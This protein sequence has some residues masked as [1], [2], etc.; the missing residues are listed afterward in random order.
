MPDKIQRIKGTN[1]I[2]PGET[3][4][5]QAL[6]RV[7]Q[8]VMMRSAYSEIRTPI[9]EKTELFA[10][11]VGEDTDIVS[12]EMYSF[13]DKGGTSIT[14]RPELTAPV[15]RS[16]IQNN[17]Q[18][19]APTTKVWYHGP[20]FRQERPQKGRYRQFY[21]FGA[22][23]IGS[24][25]PETDVETIGLYWEILTELGISDAVVLKINS[26]GD[27]ASRET[28]RQVLREFLRPNLGEMSETSQR[29][30]ETNPLRILDSKDPGDKAMTDHA[31]KLVDY[32]NE[33]SERHYK[34]VLELLSSLEI[35]YEQDDRLVRGLDYYTHTAFEFTSD[36]LG[37]QDAVCG[38]GRYDGLIEELGGGKVPAIGWASGTERLLLVMEALEKSQSLTGLDCYLAIPGDEQRPTATTLIREWR[39]A[40][41]SC[42]T[43]LQRRSLKAQ[44]RE[45]NR[46]NARFV[47]ILGE[48]ERKNGS[49]QLKSM[50]TG[51]QSEV[52]FATALKMMLGQV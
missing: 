37:A 6:E 20:L 33:S 42:D 38:G 7:I 48:S 9:F 39:R 10:R 21:Q 13:E 36:V 4:K 49:V 45:A 31:P 8:T 35:P 1:D 11:G 2:L 27:E 46:Q 51:A 32:L 34:S 18:Q 41:L 44:M 29:R 19:I 25:F 40:G 28:Y 22:E 14:L 30:F 5:W 24:P 16:Y 23:T 26:V 52:S 15:V 43:D 50:E 3:E 47:V 12:K 17:L